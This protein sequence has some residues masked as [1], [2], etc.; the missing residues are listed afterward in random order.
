MRFF[1]Y[2]VYLFLLLMA[3]SG[4]AATKHL[5]IVKP[6]VAVFKAGDKAAIAKR[7]HYPLQRKAPLQAIENEQMLIEKFEQIFD[8]EFVEKIV[9]SS[10]R[11]DWEMMG[12]RGIMFDSGK[13]WLDFDG[14]IWAV[15]YESEAE[16]ARREA[17]IDEQ[18]QALHKSLREF[19][20]P[21]LTWQTKQHLIR[22]D[23]LA[24]N[25]YR[26]AAWEVDQSMQDE[27]SLVITGGTLSFDGSGGNHFYTFTNNG[28]RYVCHVVVLGTEHSPP[29]LL[30]VFRNNVQILSEPVLAF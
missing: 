28:Y 6:V 16:K 3:F 25:Q 13:L 19:T 2:S 17:L 9:N 18:K 8:K 5:N 23:E 22:I 26:Y 12:W 15:P 20:K 30:E 10:I 27:P 4:L 14:S 21:I 29:G 1:K 24:D 7:V 11:H